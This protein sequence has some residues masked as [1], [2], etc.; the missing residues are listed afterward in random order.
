M[1]KSACPICNTNVA[2]LIE[3]NN[4][5]AAENERLK[6]LLDEYY[7]VLKKYIDVVDRRFELEQ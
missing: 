6:S 3:R 4:K 2:A 5:L 1:S 7:E